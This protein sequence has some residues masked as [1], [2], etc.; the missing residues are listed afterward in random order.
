M[1]G[2]IQQGYARKNWSSLMLFNCG[3]EKNKRLTPRMVNYFTGSQLHGM[4]W[5]ADNDIGGLPETW[6]WLEGHSSEAWEPKAVHYTRGC[7]SMPGYENTPYA[8]EW[9]GFL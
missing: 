2:Q 6:N 7:P 5:L 1:D 9:R 8:D 4:T 3:H